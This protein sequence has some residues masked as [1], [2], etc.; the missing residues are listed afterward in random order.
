MQ[1][2]GK[3]YESVSQPTT[4]HSIV[5]C[6]VVEMSEEDSD[7]VVNGV[8]EEVFP[9]A[10]L[11]LRGGRAEEQEGVRGQ[12]RVDEQEE[13]DVL[14]DADNPHLPTFLFPVYW[15]PKPPNLSCLLVCIT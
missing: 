13:V 12:V 14:K 7:M 5:A 15:I 3:K 4:E 11:E 6:S 2:K 8:T 9:P 10:K 1:N